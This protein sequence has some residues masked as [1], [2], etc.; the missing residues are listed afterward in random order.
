MNFSPTSWGLLLAAILACLFAAVEA[1]KV[2]PTT[3]AKPTFTFDQL[4]DLEKT[5]WDAFL[6]PANLKQTQGNSSTIFASDV[7]HNP[8]EPLFIMMIIERFS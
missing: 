1:S 8:F 3:H 2:S 7:W 4:W 5:F 6:Y